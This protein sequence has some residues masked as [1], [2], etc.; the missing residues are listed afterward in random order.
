[1]TFL[2]LHNC[3]SRTDVARL[4]HYADINP[5]SQNQWSRPF[6]RVSTPGTMR[7]YLSFLGIMHVG[8]ISLPSWKQGCQEGLLPALGSQTS[9]TCSSGQGSC[10]GLSRESILPG[11]GRDSYFVLHCCFA[12]A[13]CDMVV[14]STVPNAAH[15]TTL[16][17]KE[18]PQQLPSLI[19]TRSVVK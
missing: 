11:P 18:H 16:L 19:H 17:S 14:G 3:V 7:Q 5:R 2:R 10:Q 8:S 12:N 1:M 13:S 9:S 15:H 6:S 4:V